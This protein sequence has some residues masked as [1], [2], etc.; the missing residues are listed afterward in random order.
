M[1]DVLSIGDVTEDVFI[2]VPEASLHC[3]HKKMGC[4]LCVNYAS[5]IAAPRVDKLIGGNAGN[6]AIGCARLGLNSALYA[7]VG[8]DEQGSLIYR[9]LKM[10]KV[11]TRY[12]FRKKG[13]QTNYSVVLNY[14]AERTIFVHHEKR[15]YKMPRLEKAR[16]LYLTSMSQG[17][18]K[19]FPGILSYARKNKVSIAFNPGTH[20]L[21][22]GLK[23][24]LPVLRQ[25]SIIF[26][27]A[28]EA[29]FLLKTKKRDFR[30]LAKRL[31]ETGAKVAVVTDGPK[32]SYL[33][34]G[35]E[36]LYCPIFD[37]PVVERT[38]CGDSYAAAFLSALCYGCDSREAM[39][40]GTLNAASVIQQIG[41][42]AGLMHLKSLKAVLSRHPK[43]KAR[44]FD[45]KEVLKNRVYYHK[46]SKG[47]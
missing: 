14:G 41:P 17:S 8:D 3:E 46:F 45:G 10:N 36:F 20:H 2:Q 5:K 32:G 18:E 44:E 30:Y 16:W 7:E 13:E 26:L 4:L 29:Q 38:G 1:L 31:W 11:S 9:S 37:I 19:L 47:F 33:Y 42:Q 24:L 43:F 15:D 35:V 12:F 34:D 23:K 39:A 27:N 6:V 28:E 21:K 40:W 22:L 25:S